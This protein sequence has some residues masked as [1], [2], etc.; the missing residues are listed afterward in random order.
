MSD[1]VVWICNCG[2]WESPWSAPITGW[3]SW[4]DIVHTRLNCIPERFFDERWFLSG[5]NVS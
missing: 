1:D 4:R 5:D 2:Q 3:V